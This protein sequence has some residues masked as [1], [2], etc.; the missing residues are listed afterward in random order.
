L[1]VLPLIGAQLGID[2]RLASHFINWATAATIDIILRA[3]H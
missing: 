3:T 1:F 2:L